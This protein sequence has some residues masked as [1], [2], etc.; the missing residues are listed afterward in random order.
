MDELREVFDGVNVV[1]GRRR[2][3][4]DAGGGVADF[5]DVGIDFV[6]GELAAF[7][8]FCAL[9]HFDL[10]L[11]GVDEIFGGDAESGRGNL[12]DGGA[13]PVAVGVGLE[14]LGVFAAFAGVGFAAD[15][16]HGDG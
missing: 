12:L 3:E 10:E 5:A 2:D 16:V 6:A 15:A 14:A 9:G 7:A 1:M 8:G 4:A 13:T 11:V